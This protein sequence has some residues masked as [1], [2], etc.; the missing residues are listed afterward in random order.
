M[1]R[2]KKWVG[3]SA[4]VTGKSHEDKKLQCQDSVSY[5]IHDDIAILALSDGAGSCKLS[6]YGS[7]IAVKS[8]IDILKVD[9]EKIYNMDAIKAKRY[10]VSYIVRKIKLEMKNHKDSKLKDFSGTLLFVATKGSAVIVG[11]I[12][13][14]IIGYVKNG[15]AHVL[16]EPKNGESV[17]ST[18]FYTMDDVEYYFDLMKGDISGIESFIVM[19]DGTGNSLYSRKKKALSPAVVKLVNWRA[20]TSE[21]EFEEVLLDNLA[22]VIKLRTNDDCSMGIIYR[23]DMA[24]K[25]IISM[26]DV[27]LKSEII[28]IDE[29]GIDNFSMV[30]EAREHLILTGKIVST[31]SIVKMVRRNKKIVNRHLRRINTMKRVGI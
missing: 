15:N 14:G 18:Y 28:G 1:C 11:H 27:K 3:A 21:N 24:M 10:L 16:S 26:D 13:D 25:N 29:K 5:F 4:S 31:K 22:N 9:F 6:E 19:S 7:K 30:Y 17:N 2:I 20:Q 12:G 8:I 23:H